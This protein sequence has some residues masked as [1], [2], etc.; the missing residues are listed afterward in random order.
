MPMQREGW[1]DGRLAG[2][3]WGWKVSFEILEAGYRQPVRLTGSRQRLAGL[4]RADLSCLQG[5]VE[6]VVGPRD[7]GPART[8][9]CLTLHGSG[10]WRAGAQ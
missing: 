7:A 9:L 6:Q 1:G 4:P 2:A 10:I 8:A 5:G 3:S